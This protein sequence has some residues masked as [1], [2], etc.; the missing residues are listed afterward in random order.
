MVMVCMPAEFFDSHC[1]FDFTEFDGQ[2]EMQWAECVEQGILGMLIPGI[3]PAQWEV[4][5][6]ITDCYQGVWMAAGIHPWWVASST[7][8]KSNDWSDILQRKKC[9]A[10]GECGLDLAIETPLGQQQ[11]IFEQHIQLAIEHHLPLIIHVRQAHHYVIRLLKK[12]RPKRGGVIHGFTGSKEL[13]ME[14]WMM[15]FYLGVGGSITYPRAKKTRAAIQSL[16]LESLV[17][18]TDAPDMPLH[19][20]Q[21]Q[22]NSCLRI[23]DVA[24]SLAVLRSEKLDHIAQVTT[25]NS[26][27]LFNIKPQAE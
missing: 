20:H 14:Y 25:E 21:G 18:E 19:G 11:V 24:Q 4:S 23:I 3:T 10:I 7:V 6:A 15:G 12:Y 26:H 16:P 2:R 5:Y 17:L 22:P 13:A 8:P 9:V 27:S 1:H